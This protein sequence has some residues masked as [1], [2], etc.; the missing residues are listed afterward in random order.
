MN[1][2]KRL[3]IG[4]A[5]AVILGAAVFI[6]TFAQ[7]S[8]AQLGS[9]QGKGSSNP[10]NPSNRLVPQ[11]TFTILDRGFDSLQEGEKT[12]YD[13]I[14]L[15]ANRSQGFVAICDSD[16]DSITLNLINSQGITVATGQGGVG[17]ITPKQNDTFTLEVNMDRCSSTQSTGVPCDFAIAKFGILP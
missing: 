4:S 17:V 5:I 16:C 2:K 13:G 14:S 3:T 7:Q 10:S 9:S 15:Q 8:L 6:P 1:L 12:R 11:G